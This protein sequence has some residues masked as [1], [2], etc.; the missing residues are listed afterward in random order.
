MKRYW[1]RI[2]VFLL[3]LALA[4]YVLWNMRPKPE[5]AEY[6]KHA[7][8]V[9]K[10]VN[11]GTCKPDTPVYRYVSWNLG[12]FGKS[13][14]DEEIR[15]MA[16]I[17]VDAGAD[18]VAGQ[19][20]STGPP[21]AQA[22]ARLQD[23]LSRMGSKWDSLHSPV[24]QPASTGSE[25]Y[26]FWFNTARF[27]A[28]R[29]EAT[30]VQELEADIDREP[31]TALFSTKAGESLRIYQIHAVPTKKNPL[32]EVR[33]LSKYSG[34]GKNEQSII[35]SG[36]FN[37]SPTETDPLL[38]PLGFSSLIRGLTSLKQLPAQGVYL[39]RQYDNIYTRGKF[40]VCYSGIL[41]F[42]KRFPSPIS[43]DD[44]KKARAISD[45]LPVIVG[46]QFT[47]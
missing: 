2:T 27:H 34:F 36:D 20:V 44:F 45:H 12:N 10:R 25:R 7:Q 23:E 41:D 17:I 29:K 31:F 18:I 13:K 26:A 32:E 28:N 42:T 3:L 24:T 15:A 11:F 47:N 8:R 1:G 43:N 35:L 19:E 14:S 4:M 5:V 30:L 37:L 22:V 33:T 21:G 16:E 38:V 9:E 40:T 6:T 46:L 39:N